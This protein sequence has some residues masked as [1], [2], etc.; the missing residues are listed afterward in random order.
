MLLENL[1]NNKNLIICSHDA[2]GANILASYLLINKLKDK[3]KFLLSG[4]AVKIYN[5]ILG[6]IQNH[7]HELSEND[8]ILITST[9][10][11]SNSERAMIKQARDLG[12]ITISFLDHWS[13]YQLRFTGSVEVVEN[14]DFFLPN[15]IV[16]NDDKAYNKAIEAKFPAEKIIQI[17]NPY[18]AKIK[19]EFESLKINPNYDVLYISE[20]FSNLQKEKLTEQM[21]LDRILN[22]LKN[23]NKN[24]KVKIRLHPS[25][26]LD[27]YATIMSKYPDV[28]FSDRSITLTEDLASTKMVIGKSSMALYI[29]SML[30]IETYSIE[31]EEIIPGTLSDIVVRVQNLKEIP[32]FR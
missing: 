31:Y 16:V 24:L 11:E 20:Y 5:D 19:K 30:N 10:G 22:D 28:H 15:Y 18:I 21:Y 2:G 29:S 3:C 6:E 23:I 8:K 1:V 13:N 26:E 12:V 7:Q 27:K 14:V 25:E 17:Q 9:S 32:K 4:P